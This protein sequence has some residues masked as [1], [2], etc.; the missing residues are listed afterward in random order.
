MS[1]GPICLLFVIKLR[2][3]AP[4]YSARDRSPYT[5]EQIHLSPAE[6]NGAGCSRSTLR[7][8]PR[9]QLRSGTEQPAVG[10]RKKRAVPMKAFSG[11]FSPVISP[12]IKGVQPVG[13]ARFLVTFSRVGKSHPG[14]AGAEG[15]YHPPEGLEAPRHPATR[16]WALVWEPFSS[17]PAGQSIWPVRPSAAGP[18]P[19]RAPPPGWPPP[20]SSR[21]AA[22]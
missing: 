16:R 17:V 15:P 14:W 7:Q 2:P 21:W 5:G 11:S 12:K 13:L 4:C 3:G 8:A 19:R 9:R 20:W 6:W 1:G 22:R 18:G 10:I